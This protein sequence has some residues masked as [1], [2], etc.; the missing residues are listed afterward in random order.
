MINM[1]SVKIK[2]AKTLE[3][4]YISILYLSEESLLGS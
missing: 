3:T 2:I 1:D 4:L